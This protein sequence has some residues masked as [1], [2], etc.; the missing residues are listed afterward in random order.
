LGLVLQ[1]LVAMWLN[2]M[3][4]PWEV[5]TFKWQCEL[6]I[7]LLGLAFLVPGAMYGFVAARAPWIDGLGVALLLLLI[8]VMMRYLS[9]WYGQDTTLAI[10]YATFFAVI[11]CM[12]A[13]L[14]GYT[15]RRR[16]DAIAL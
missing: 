8:G 2:Y 1:V 13:S 4:L 16:R 12:L 10:V 7:P 3:C 9:P 5:H 15:L 6:N 14:A 11:P